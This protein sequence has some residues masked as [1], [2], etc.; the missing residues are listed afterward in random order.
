MNTNS[1]NDLVVQRHFL[2]VESRYFGPK[3][4][5]IAWPG[6]KA[7]VDDQV[8]HERANG[9]A[10]CKWPG[11]WPCFHEVQGTQSFGLGQ[12]NAWAVGPK[13]S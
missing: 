11:R 1:G 2:D 7:Q 5:P 9:P 3:V 4:Q 6:Q 12:V 13:V 8:F 10:V